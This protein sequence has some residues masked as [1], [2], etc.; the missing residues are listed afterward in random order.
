MRSLR[1]LGLLVCGGCAMPPARVAPTPLEVSGCEHVHRLTANLLSGSEPRGRAGL[2]ALAKLGI[3]T[4]ISVDGARPD[5]ATAAELGMRYVHL[6]FG[7]DGVPR[8][9][10][11]E[12]ARA[13]RDLPGPVY[14]HC[15]HGLHRGPTG[16]AAALVAL[17]Q[18]SGEEAV[19]MM[20]RLG[21]AES[22]QGLYG[23]VREL[24]ASPADVDGASA[25]FPPAA[26]LPGFVASMVLVDRRWENLAI[27]KGAGWKQSPEHPDVDPAHEALQLRELVTELRRTAHV[28][29]QPDDF[30]GWMSACEAGAGALEAALRKGDGDAADAGYARVKAS[31]KDC[32]QAY[33]NRRRK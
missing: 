15:H 17:G 28:M 27:V 25:E 8:E 19:G 7:Y 3:K 6:P 32:H 24:T 2:E 18:C 20:K 1:L 12:I 13:V 21:T 33:R 23:D 5:A 10:A 4:I 11:L 16:A 14:I 29:A 31:C 30:Q 22:Y 26:R 9:R